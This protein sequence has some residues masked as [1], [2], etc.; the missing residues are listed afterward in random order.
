MGPHPCQ[1]ALKPVA[2]IQGMTFSKFR[3]NFVTTPIFLTL[4][5]RKFSN[6]RGPESISYPQAASLNATLPF[7]QG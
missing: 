1:K 6:D 5:G 3:L 7:N 2:G 4:L